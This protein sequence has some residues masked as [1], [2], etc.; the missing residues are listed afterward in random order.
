MSESVDLVERS[1]SNDTE[2]QFL[3]RVN[4]QA[5]RLREALRNG[6][7]DNP[8]FGVGLE[9][10]VYGVDPD[11]RLATV[12]DASY[13]AGATKELGV[14]NAEINTDP[15]PLTESGL[16]T[17]AERIAT[18]FDAAD[19]AAATGDCQLVT[20]AMWTVPPEEGSEA[21]LG[22][23]ETHDGVVFAENMRADPRYTALDNETLRLTDGAIQ[24]DVPGIDRTFPSILFE[25]LATSIQPHLQIPTAERFPEY[26]NAAIRT[27]G[28]V[29]A[30]STNSPFLP[31]DLYS[32]GADPQAV[33]DQTHH[34]L[35]IA[36]FEQSMNVTSS[37]KVRVPRDIDEP[38]DVVDRIV[39]DDLFAPFL[40]EWITD[41]PRDSFAE[42]F[43]E[44]AYKRSTY[45]RWLRCV[46]GGD[47][48]GDGDERSLRIEYRPIPTQPTLEGVVSMQWL[49]V[50]LIRGLVERE[51]PLTDLSWDLAETSFYNA[52]RESLSGTLHWM[53]A[54]G[55]RTTDTDLLFDDLFET[56]R[57]GLAAAG[58]GE[59]AIDD[60]LQP[61]ERR[62]ETRT[63]PSSWKRE[64]V[65]ERVQ[66]GDDLSTAITA[67]QRQY[68][69]Q[70]R[71][72]DSFAEWL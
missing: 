18:Q 11:C 26:Y 42:E 52:A 12:P 40:R 35:R 50:G 3:D 55:E 21:Y 45:W 57:A 1:L 5:D 66:A 23:T 63:T 16:E 54:D 56:A 68:V 33:L 39:E 65:R 58:V 43:W 48:V 29:L 60:R 64:R 41:E 10:E 37:P 28:P 71:S 4:R 7:L 8:G 20:D 51:H 49:T 46:I 2:T 24:F 36:V 6:S 72:T 13:E 47:P 17:Q 31:P 53:T 27:L 69:E 59:T 22:A 15:D 61:L 14:H 44:F 62:V 9:M 70:S 32:E 25:S 30:L 67:M 38:E 19:D 34:E